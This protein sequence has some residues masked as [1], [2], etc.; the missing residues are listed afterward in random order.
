M[1]FNKEKFTILA[2]IHKEMDELHKRV[3]KEGYISLRVLKLYNFYIH[4]KR[5]IEGLDQKHQ[6]HRVNNCKY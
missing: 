2:L 3:E 1:S 5:M 4:Q 6:K